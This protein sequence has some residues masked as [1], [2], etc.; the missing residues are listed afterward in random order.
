MNTEKLKHL[1]QF[2]GGDDYHVN[3][4]GRMK[5]TEG[6]QYLAEN[7]EAYW[8][9]DAIASYQPQ[10]LKVETFRYLQFWELKVNPDRSCLLTC[11]EDSGIEP[12]VEQKIEFTDFPLPGIKLWVEH[13][14][15]ILPSEH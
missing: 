12:A 1:N 5:Y 11:R 3:P 14:V 10:L 15:L 6:V 2:T 4:I 13:G 8:L 7:A 9:I